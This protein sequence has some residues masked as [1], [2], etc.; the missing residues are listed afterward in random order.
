MARQAA[1]KYHAEDVQD[2]LHSLGFSQRARKHGATVIVESGPK[3]G[4]LEHSRLRR[5]TVHL[6]LLDLAD[7]HGRW[8]RTPYREQLEALVRRVAEEFPWTLADASTNPERTSDP[9]N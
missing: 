4:P 9:E 5:D 6:W 7:H 2:C 8:E 1:E 3:A